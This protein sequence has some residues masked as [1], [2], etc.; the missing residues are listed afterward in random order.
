MN[1]YGKWAPTAFDSVGAF[2]ENREDWLVLPVMRTRDSGPMAESNFE[3][4]WSLV[5]DASVLDNE[6][7]CENHRFGHWGPGWFKIIIVRPGSHCAK[8]AEEIEARLGDYP[9]LDD[10]DYSAREW[11][12][13]TE[14]WARCYNV[15]ERVQLIQE[16]NRVLREH[17]VSVFAARRDEIPQG[18]HGYIFDRCRPEE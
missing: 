9:V 8:V 4:A 2:L 14:T 12:A 5:E 7:S 11:E 15:R 13:A 6:L 1:R 10:D 16:H 18:D 3:S 17:C